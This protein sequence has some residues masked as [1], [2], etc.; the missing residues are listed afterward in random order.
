M[1][2]LIN[3]LDNIFLTKSNF[4][5]FSDKYISRINF[6]LNNRPRKLL[7]F[8]NPNELFFNNYP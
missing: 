5:D 6:K 4:D 2:I 7:N 3:L 8:F 1:N